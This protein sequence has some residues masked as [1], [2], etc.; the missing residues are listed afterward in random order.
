[1]RH[2]LTYIN[3]VIEKTCEK[4]AIACTPEF[5]TF[6]F[7]SLKARFKFGDDEFVEGISR[8]CRTRP[9][10][11]EMAIEDAIFRYKKQHSVKA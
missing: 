11:L 3:H 2:E 10:E 9:H 4:K 7:N 8:I 5:E 1:M 6:L